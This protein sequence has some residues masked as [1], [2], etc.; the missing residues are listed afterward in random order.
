MW[1][2]D[3]AS[4]C[5]D[6][7]SGADVEVLPAGQNY[8]YDDW[9]WYLAWSPDSRWLAVPIQPSESLTNLA[10]VPADGSRPAV[11]PVPSGESQW[12]PDWSPDG[13][14][15][16]WGTAVD[17][18]HAAFEGRWTADF[19]GALSRRAMRARRSSAG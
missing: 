12:G 7:A 17:S 3:R 5:S 4:G 6:P 9:S 13:G 14:L 10:L 19:E 2:T 15:L 11:R 16:T 18:L 1:R 8:S